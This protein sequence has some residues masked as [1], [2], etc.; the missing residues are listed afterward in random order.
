MLACLGHFYSC[1]SS[2]KSKHVCKGKKLGK[3]FKQHEF[4]FHCGSDAQRAMAGLR[5]DLP[6]DRVFQML[7]GVCPKH[8]MMI[9]ILL[10]VD[11]W[12]LLDPLSDKQ[13]LIN[14]S[15]LCSFIFTFLNIFMEVIYQIAICHGHYLRIESLVYVCFCKPPNTKYKNCECSNPVNK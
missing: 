1:H 9:W 5:D 4:C 8:L 10:M 3:I 13:Q 2:I 11:H 7:S 15:L 6:I 12:L 14:V